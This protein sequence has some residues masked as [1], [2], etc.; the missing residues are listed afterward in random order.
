MIGLEEG[1]AEEGGALEGFALVVHN[2]L[3][4]RVHQLELG[5]CLLG[6]EYGGQQSAESFGTGELGTH[7]V[8][9]VV[10]VVVVCCMLLLLLVR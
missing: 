5:S 6:E 4:A 2:D 9:I 7:N 3:D 1:F 8:T 10:H